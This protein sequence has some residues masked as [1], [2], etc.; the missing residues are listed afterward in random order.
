MSQTPPLHD[1]PIT[2]TAKAVLD[3]ALAAERAAE[4]LGDARLVV[5]EESRHNLDLMMRIF[6]RDQEAY[7]SWV[8]SQPRST[9]R[10]LFVGCAHLAVDTTGV[11]GTFKFSTP[12]SVVADAEK[13]VSLCFLCF[14][15]L[16]IYFFIS[17]EKRHQNMMGSALPTIVATTATRRILAVVVAEVEV[18]VAIAGAAVVLLGLKPSNCFGF[19][20]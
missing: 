19:F 20:K 3:A 8:N 5:Y 6:R 11:R 12:E 16:L 17:S 18:E 13:A 4:Q 10:R 15:Y 2:A 9:Q 7:R 1:P 14:F